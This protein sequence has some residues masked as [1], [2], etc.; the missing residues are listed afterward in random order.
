MEDT[1]KKI[2]DLLYTARKDGV[3]FVLNG[4]NLQLRY[5]ESK[6]INHDLLQEIKDNKFTI[7]EFLKNDSWK[8]RSVNGSK[9][10]V[11]AFDRATLLQIPLSFAQER[12]WFIDKL[13]GSIPYHTVVS[14][15]LKGQLNKKALEFAL[16]N[17]IDR[18]QVLRTIYYDLDGIGYQKTKETTQWHLSYIDG[19]NLNNNKPLLANAIDELVNQPFHLDRDFMLRASLISL[20]P[21]EFVLVVV[22]HH[23]ACDA[24]SAPI[25]IKEVTELYGRFITGE[26]SA[27]S[28]LPLQF[29]DYAVWE[30]KNLSTENLQ[31]KLNYWK[32][33]LAGVSPLQLPYDFEAPLVRTSRGGSVSYKI[34]ASTLSSLND[35]SKQNDCSLYMVLLAAYN[36]LLYRYSNQKD[37]SVGASVANRNQPEIESLVGFFVNTVVFRNEIET[38]KSFV[39]LLK[40]VK[41]TTLEAYEHQDVPFEKVVETVL[42]ERETG[43]A[44]LFQVML[45]FINTPASERTKLGQLEVMQEPFKS[46]VSKFDFTFFINELANGLNIVV[47]YSA[48]LFKEATIIQLLNNYD[49]LLQAIATD[50]N[51]FVA[52]IPLLSGKEEQLLLNE[53]GSNVTVFPV[54]ENIV[55]LFEE[56]VFKNLDAPAMVCDGQKL[57]Y[58]QLNEKANQ[59]AHYLRSVDIGPNHYVPIVAEA[60]LKLAIGIMGILKSGAAYVPIDP[61]LPA[62]RIRFILQ[63]TKATVAILSK[64]QTHKVEPYELVAVIDLDTIDTSFETQLTSN[65]KLVDKSDH[66]AYVIYTSGST[67]MPKGVMISHQNLADYVY[68]IMDKIA[69]NKCSS[70][71]LLSSAAT[72]LGNTVIYGSLLTGG[73]LHL[74]STDRLNNAYALHGYFA[75]HAID[76]IKIVPSHWNALQFDNKNLL[77]SKL[78]IFGGEVLYSNMI[79]GVLEDSPAL[80]VVNHYGPTET[81]IGKLLHVIDRN[82]RYG[83]TIPIGKPFGNTTVYVLSN[84]L[85]LAPKGVPGKLFIEGKGL[86]KGYLNNEALTNK[87][88]I[89]NPFKCASQTL[90]YDTGDLVKYLPDGNIVFINRAD[91]QVKIR[92]YRVELGEI[93]ATLLS[94]QGIKQAVALLKEDTNGNKKLAAYVIAEDNFDKDEVIGKLR[95]QLPDYMVPSFVSDL[96]SFPLLPNG[97]VDRRLLQTYQLEAPAKKAYMPPQNETEEKLAEIWK[98]VLELDDISI[99]DDFFEQG[100]HSLLAIRV[101][102]AIR[103]IFKVEV[104]IGD[105]FDYPT[106][107]FLARQIEANR[108]NEILKAITVRVPGPKHIPLSFSQ[109]RL[110]VINQLSGTVNYHIPSVFRLVGNLDMDV[111][112]K[113]FLQVI[114]RHEAL[115]TVF[116]ENGTTWQQVKQSSDWTLPVVDKPASENELNNLIK[117]LIN[118]PFDLSADYMIRAS[119]I[120]QDDLENLLIIT[121]HHI[122]SDAWSGTILINE[123]TE[124]YNA[125]VEKREPRL[126]LLPIQYADFALW[127]REQ[128]QT[129]GWQSKIDFWKNH[130]KGISVLQLPTD[131]L[132]PQVQS[133]RGAMAVYRF[134][135]ELVGELNELNRQHGATMFMTLLGAFNVLLYKYTQQTDICIGSPIAGRQLQEVEGLVGFF[136][137]TIVFRTH[138]NEA[139]SFSTLLNKVRDNT[140]ATAPFHDI[141][142]E[143]VVEATVNVRDT[144]R[145]PIFQVAFSYQNLSE[146]NNADLKGISLSPFQSDSLQH[147]TSKFDLTFNITET[148]KGLQLSV[149]YCTDVFKVQTV[150]RMIANYTRLL[151]EVSKNPAISIFQLPVIADAEQKQLLQFND[152]H[153]D[154]PYYS[155]LAALF[156]QH[157]L[158]SLN[159]VAI[160]FGD[161]SLTYQQLH[162]RS[163]QVAN[164]LT[165]GGISQGQV[166][167][168]LA[169]RGFD[170]IVGIWGI[171]KLGCTYVPLNT[172]FPSERLQYIIQNSGASALVYSDSEL[173]QNAGINGVKNFNVTDAKTFNKDFKE[174]DFLP[175]TPVYIMYTSGTSGK[176]KGIKVSQQNIINVALQKNEIKVNPNDRMLQWS[177]YGFD[178]SVYEIFGAHLNGAALC[179]L[180]E[181][182][183]ADV[184]AI[185]KVIVNNKVSICFITTAIFNAIADTNPLIFNKLRKVLFGGESV[186]AYQVKRVI[187]AIGSNKIV[188]VY[189][190]TETTVYATS[191]PLN[192]VVENEN[193]PIG[194]PLNNVKA[195]VLDAHQNPVPVGV[196]GELYIGGKGVSIGY[197]NN[198]A[199]TKEKFVELFF[200]NYIERLYRTGDL[201]R[202]NSDGLLEFM[203]RI[204]DQVK[205]RGYRIE[206]S[207]IEAVLQENEM[208]RSAYVNVR[209]YQGFKSLIAYVIVGEGFDKLKLTNWLRSKVPD[210]MVPAFWVILDKFPLNGNGKIDRN[211][212]PEPTIDEGNVSKSAIPLTDLEKRLVEMWQLLLGISNIGIADNFFELGGDSILSIQFVNLARRNNIEIQPRDLFLYQSI[213]QL[214][215][216]ITDNTQTKIEGEQG[217]LTGEAGL[218]PVQQWFFENTGPLVSHFNQAL[219]LGIEKEITQSQLNQAWAILIKHHDAL[220]FVY[221]NEAGKWSQQ[222]GTRVSQ[223][224]EETID[225]ADNAT[226]KKVMQER[227]NHYQ[228]SLNIFEGEIVKIILFKTPAFE[229][230]NRML[231]VVHH[232]AVDGVSWRILIENLEFCL[233]AIQNNEVPNLGSKGSSYRQWY[234]SLNKYG[235]QHPVIEEVAF[236]KKTLEKYEPIIRGSGL[237]HRVRIKDISSALMSLSQAQTRILVTEVPKIFQTEINDA[238]LC[239]LALSLK[240]WGGISNITIGMEGFGR[241]EIDL[242]IDLSKSVGWFTNIYPVVIETGE[243][244]EPFDLLPMV[245][246]QLRNI[247][248]KGLGFGVLKYL[249]HD[250][251]LGIN[252]K[253]N[254]IFNYLGQLDSVTK[255]GKWISATGDGVGSSI[256]E[257]HFVHEDLSLNGSIQNGR[258]LF[259]VGYNTKNLSAAD[260]DEFI[261]TFQSTLELLIN[262]CMQIGSVTTFENEIVSEAEE[263]IKEKAL[264]KNTNNKYL[265]PIKVTGKKRPLYI[266]A[267]GG[268]TANKFMRFAKMLDIEQP[269]YALQ[270]PVDYKD[271]Q[272]FPDTIEKIAEKFIE[273]I[274]SIDPVGPYA[275]SGHC[276]GGKI[277]FEMARQLT[278]AGKKVPVLAMFDTLVARNVKDEEPGI[279]N[280]YNIPLRARRLGSRILLKLDFEAYLLINHTKKALNYKLNSIKNFL[281]HLI[282]KPKLDENSFHDQLEIFQ[283]TSDLYT[284]A[285]R[286]YKMVPYNNEVILFYAKERYYFV[287][288]SNNINFKKIDLDMNSKNAW[289]DYAASV[290]LYE[291]KGD[292]SDIFE[293][294]HGDEFAMLLQERLN[295]LT[296][297][298]E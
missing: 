8:T 88:F 51:R 259:N 89:S 203:G 180:Q 15:R 147:T 142:F 84:N 98:E 134:N 220:R 38:G 261:T 93:E 193:I 160:V 247:P 198:E 131:F 157:V 268:G 176:P 275:L 44:S 64:A 148:H 182:M 254:I 252:P 293:S 114:E 185:E 200:N 17:V 191:C 184:E 152:T 39:D 57:S 265:I 156:K 47:E 171:I 43:K 121:L 161:T 253:W 164:Q 95:Q 78:L 97:K 240:K 256:N 233:T 105:I 77:P 211:A 218:L 283:K 235:Q 279:Q 172:G 41:T 79:R 195:F 28:L 37:I 94:L 146:G 1:F 5:A 24:W 224:I 58:Y 243:H 50:P 49:N 175:E 214:A 71:A 178:G 149:E 91:D 82:T 231:A 286:K 271:L 228:Q 216:Y 74:F 22:V 291:I 292:H 163:G 209:N 100:G 80:T 140:L 68:G 32:Q 61:G 85:T 222:Y 63:D 73:C 108:E 26:T 206:P 287:D 219:M 234:Q 92:G 101:V 111:L 264:L 284:R 285:S 257:E 31:P 90:M 124:C 130:L 245:K 145:N 13:E 76:C 70:F 162:E 226:L 109:E 232:L 212:L 223:V 9:K 281:K 278:N 177:N 135:N 30:K 297:V 189:G 290:S 107:S 83:R 56:Q 141:P 262:K 204:D 274:V 194:K 106:I 229:N 137:N 280:V 238:L 104:P 75:E 174:V 269:V 167:A 159:S 65:P 288:V 165:A 272:A 33:K 197:V 67:G 144:S 250:E 129:D 54:E 181:G 298:N 29:V 227:S 11:E 118:K 150:Q 52:T 187:D 201:V 199:L 48:E 3:E 289:K 192:D 115:R 221:K 42:K 263:T 62:E 120:R 242:N 188:H 86:A 236:W 267:G 230:K 2:V 16:E 173:F 59:L 35:L 282:L 166:V 96:Q 69:I 40:Q 196:A 186:S 168:L 117:T 273:E 81:T 270:P 46:K 244:T 119:I 128:A 183:A 126:N 127:Q 112:S 248:V 294:I 158:T 169:N 143:K 239:C 205:I 113:A 20:Q 136:I 190:P 133:L 266:V 18:H 276:T 19:S 103:K 249:N 102:S 25:I 246:N 210:Y 55:D 72:D 277:A 12:L 10:L 202:W 116:K 255:S 295:T 132:R 23:I 123:L 296:N 207:E 138:I 7:I 36:V 258:L 27:L 153:S 260:I 154:M 225:A 6:S 53:F 251:K 241:N 122:A 45:V 34:N 208:V 4:D 237:N 215:Q 217:F 110:W 125:G 21:N 14:L 66:V 151:S 213:A 179:L 60:G 170:M 87:K 139:E 99:N 155:G